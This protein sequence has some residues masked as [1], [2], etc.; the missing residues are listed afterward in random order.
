MYQ[1]HRRHH[2]HRQDGWRTS[3]YSFWVIQ[4]PGP[5]RTSMQSVQ[6]W[7][8]Q[9]WNWVPRTHHFSK[10]STTVKHRYCCN[11]ATTMSRKPDSATVISGK[12]NFITSTFLT[13]LNLLLHSISY[14]KR[15]YPSHGPRLKKMPSTNWRQLLSTRHDLFISAQSYP[16]FWLRMHRLMALELYFRTGIQTDQRNQ[17]PSHPRHW[18]MQ[19]ETTA[20]LKKKD[21]Q[22]SL[23]C[24]SSTNTFMGY[25]NLLS[26]KRIT[27]RLLPSSHQI[28]SYQ[29]YR[30]NVC[31][32]GLFPSCHTILWSSI[33][34]PVNIPTQMPCH[35]YQWDLTLLSTR[36]KIPVTT[37]L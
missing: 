27:S 25:L 4:T 28:T 30:C 33:V 14:A 3:L 34:L 7:I 17:S 31:S 36:W 19:K 37:S 22:S 13:T 21:Y 11:Q 16:S 9:V 2:R 5:E 24:A 6:V 29:Y 32:D 20:K 18:Q 15:M 1:L 23:V 26:F 8:L 35:D 10:R 12:I